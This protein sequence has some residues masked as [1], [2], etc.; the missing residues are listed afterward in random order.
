MPYYELKLSSLITLLKRFS[1]EYH[2]TMSAKMSQ[3]A[4]KDEFRKYLEK[5]GVLELLTK[6]LVQ[7]YEEPEKPSDGLSYMKKAVGGSPADKELIASLQKENDELKAKVSQLEAK[8]SKLQ[9]SLAELEKKSE[10][11]KEAVPAEADA[12]VE[13]NTG[14]TSE[15]SA[16]APAE[17][18]D[19]VAAAAVPTTVATEVVEEKAP[20]E[21]SSEAM[22][23]TT[24]EKTEEPMET[25]SSSATPMETKTDPPTGDA[26]AEPTQE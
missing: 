19:A 17:E 8:Q 14:K 4:K 21:S 12:Q 20:V 3:D 13:A 15:E 18:K 2:P 16:A 7:L 6:S 11:V 25:E 23:A 1:F 24:D 26:P 5:A 9:E 10:Q 22:G